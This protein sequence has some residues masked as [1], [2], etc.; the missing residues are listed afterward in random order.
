MSKGWH[1]IVDDE[2]K[3]IAPDPPPP[4]KSNKKDPKFTYKRQTLIP[5]LVLQN[6]PHSRF[7]QARAY[8]GG[9]ATAASMKTDDWREAAQ[10]AVVWFVGI[11]SRADHGQDLR[12]VSWREMTEDY[13]STLTQGSRRTYHVETI[14]RH[15]DP[16]FAKFR[17]V[18]QI[19]SA[20]ILDFLTYRRTKTK[21]EPLPQTINRETSVL[22]ALLD[23]ARAKRWIVVMPEIPFLNESM[24]R[25]RREHF[26]AEELRRLRVAAVRR[27]R[28]AKYG[29]DNRERVGVLPYRQ[30]LYDV[31]EIMAN[32]GLRVGE[33]HTVRW[34]DIL[35]EQGDIQLA[36]A[37]KTRSSR[38]LILKQP[39]I[40]ALRR[41][42]LRRLRWQR[43]NGDA[44]GLP[45]HER[46]VALGCGTHVRQMKSSWE[47]L[48]AEAGFT[49]GEGQ[50]PHVLTSL[51]HTYATASLTRM[52]KPRPPIHVLALQMGTSIRMITRHYAHDT[53]DQ[54]R[55]ELG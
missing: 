30:L 10:R 11:K 28:S 37:G 49:Y 45:P 15:L 6:Q 51:R 42:A 54:Y 12:A 5:G 47:G 29:G 25:R 48:L 35:W 24:T 1:F 38:R 2:D 20:V 13:A 52:D 34:R 22:R 40:R 26:T 44:V 3:A 16:F 21:R 50:H 7:I 4:S 14:A 27:I 32:S 43:E 41:L 23:H 39:A 18:S 55:D 53:V 46:V 17:D 36:H 9:N 8:I 19:T 31:I 33:L